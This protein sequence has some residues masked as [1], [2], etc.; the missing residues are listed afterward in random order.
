MKTRQIL[1]FL[2]IILQGTS[3]FPSITGEKM[4]ERLKIQ[5]EK[6][7][8]DSNDTE[9][10]REISYLYLQ[11][12]DYQ[13]AIE[14][15]T[16]LFNRGYEKEDYY[17][18]ILQAHICLG[19]AYTMTGNIRLAYS[20]LGQ[21]ER[22]ALTAHNDSALCS[23][24]NGKGLYALNLQ[25]DCYQ[26]LEYFF[27]GLETAGRIPYDRLTSILLTNISSVYYLKKDTTGLK[28]TLECY[29]LGNEKKD[30]YLTYC[31]AATTAY[32]YYLKQD[33]NNAFTYAQEAENLMQVHQFRNQ[34]NIYSLLGHIYRKTGQPIQA[35]TCYRKALKRKGQNDWIALSDACQGYATLLMEQQ[36][37]AEAIRLLQQAITESTHVPSA[38]FRI[39]LLQ[40]LSACLEHEGYIKEALAYSKQS[41]AE[42][43]SLYNEAKERSMYEI[44]TRYQIDQHEAALQRS[45]VELIKKENNLRI[46]FIGIITLSI[47]VGMLWYLYHRKNRLYMAIVRQNREALRREKE[48]TQRLVKQQQELE[49]PT[50][51]PETQQTQ[52]EKYA[53]S[54]LT[55]DKKKD[56][57]LRFEKLMTE[58]KIYTDNLLTKEKAA[59]LLGTNR[60]YLSQVIN[61][62][63]SQTFTQY[64]NSCRAKEAVRL[65]SD[66]ENN[67]P[68]KAISAQLGFNS[69]TTFYHQ[70]QLITEMTPAQYRSKM[71]DLRKIEADSKSE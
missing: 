65:L 53:S 11:K 8:T 14:Y 59:E 29:R 64:V 50:G 62:E 52:T 42:A 1:L 30:S 60:T 12:A 19:Q 27:K 71:N 63:T 47:I 33:W 54:T 46:L 48:L 28:Y 23:I 43:D 24:Y 18:S 31:G 61:E 13:K 58:E 9:A 56:L 7:D 41:M 10:L 40:K 70:F 3:A 39:G 37:F 16:R 20:N 57:F 21:A 22:L 6:L 26:A 49:Y 36:R 69:M 51:S 2:L 17:G 15:G 67:T 45:K 66:P 32:M 44:R 25:N 5:E 68:L 34:S 55:T 35:E 4:D 38:L